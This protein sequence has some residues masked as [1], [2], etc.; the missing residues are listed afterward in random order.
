MNEI[1]LIMRLAKSVR[2]PQQAAA[3]IVAAIIGVGL[4]YFIPAD[5]I[6]NV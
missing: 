5:L 1:K 4:I 2:T 3:L 6:E